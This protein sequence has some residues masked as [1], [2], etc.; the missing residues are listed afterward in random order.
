MQQE[1][2]FKKLFITKRFPHFFKTIYVTGKR[3]KD[4]QQKQKW[5]H[6]TIF[7]LMTFLFVFIELI[8][9]VFVS[10]R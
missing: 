7:Y 6:K 5:K 9:S 10:S 3:P 4:P 8:I 2:Y 1:K